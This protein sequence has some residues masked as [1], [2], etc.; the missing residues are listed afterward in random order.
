MP[1]GICPTG[2][3]SRLLA[4]V[5]S[6]VR[7]IVPPDRGRGVC[8]HATLGAVLNLASLASAES[9][10]NVITSP[11]LNRFRQKVRVVETEENERDKHTK[12]V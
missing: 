5:T 4:G 9:A 10:P 8:S 2:P 12:V 11:M 3:N 6:R 1:R 7:S